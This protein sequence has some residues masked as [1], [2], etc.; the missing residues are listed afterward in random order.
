MIDESHFNGLKA[1]DLLFVKRCSLCDERFLPT[2]YY[3][4]R[5]PECQVIVDRNEQQE[6]EEYT[7]EPDGYDLNVDW[8]K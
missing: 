3:Y 8:Y 5:C 1:S 6:H 7:D 2:K 4:H